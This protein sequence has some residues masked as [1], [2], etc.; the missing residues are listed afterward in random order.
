L[1]VTADVPGAAGRA[2]GAG[3]DPAVLL[4]PF[5]GAQ[6]LGGML[7]PVLAQDVVPTL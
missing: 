5:P 6:L 4:P 2:D 1:E 7:A 3:E